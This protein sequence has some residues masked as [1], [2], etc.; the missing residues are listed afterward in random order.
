MGSQADFPKPETAQEPIAIVGMACRFPG[1]ATS[2]SKLWD[3][4]AAGQDGWSPIPKSRFDAE[5]LYHADKERLGRSH[6]TGGYF[7]KEDVALFDAPF[8]NFPAELAKVSRRKWEEGNTRYSK[9]HLT[10]FPRRWTPRYVC[11]SRSSTK[12]PRMVCHRPPP[13]LSSTNPRIA[14]RE[15]ICTAGVPLERLAGSDTSVFAGCFGK[16]YYD[17]LTRDLELLP[18]NFFVGTSITMISNRISHFYDLKGASVTLDTA[19]SSGLVALHQAC[20][21]LRSGESSMAIVGAANAMLSPDLFVA[22]STLGVVGKD[23]KCYAWDPR[24]EGYGRG[25]GVAAL[26][27][28]PLAAALADGDHVHSVIRD[29]GLN[30]DG[31]TPTITSPSLDAQVDLIRACYRRAGLDMSETGYVE[32]HMTGTE[33]GDATEAEALGRTFGRS[34]AADDGPVVVGSVKTNIGHTEAVSGLAAVIKATLGLRHRM[35]AP[36]LNFETTSPKIDAAGWHLTVPT[37]PQPWPRDKPLRVSINNFGYGGTNAHVILEGASSHVPTKP[38]RNGLHPSAANGTGHA[39]SVPKVYVVTAKD[40][41]ALEKASGELAAHLRR[42]G[43]QGHDRP[44]EGDLAYTLAQRRSRFP[45]VSAVRAS[46]LDDLVDGLEDPSR[47][48]PRGKAPGKVPRV[49]FVFNGQGAQWYRMGR[50][51]IAAYPVF[52]TAIRKADEAFRQLGAEWSLF[53]ELMRDEESTRVSRIDLTQPITVALQICLVD[54]LES[55]GIVPEAVC[56]HSSG[57]IAAAYAAGALT[58]VEA[59]GVVYFRGKLALEHLDA[60]SPASSG[61]IAAGIGPDQAR[62]YIGDAGVT[63]AGRVV[64]ACVNSPESVTLS[65]DM[66]AID[67]VLE[68]LNGDGHFARKLKVPVAYHSHHMLPMAKDYSDCLHRI[69]AP[70][71][72]S[73]GKGRRK[74]PEFAS[75]VTGGLVRAR[76]LSPEHWVRNLTNPVLFSQAFESMCSG[77]GGLDEPRADSANAANSSRIDY[78]VEIGPHSTLFGPIRQ[79]LNGRSLGYASCL[80]RGVDAVETMQDMVCNLLV[81]GYPVDLTAVNSPTGQTHTLV[82]GLPTYPWNHSNRYWLESRL[83]RELRHKKFPP[84]ELLGLPLSGSISG[85]KHTWRNFLRVADIP[86]LADHRVDSA[87]VLPAAA[88]I[89]MAIE[90]LRLVAAPSEKTLRGYALRDVDIRNALSIPESSVGVEVQTCLSPCDE[91]E[92][93]HRGWYEFE[94]F[95]LHAGGTWIE[96][97]KGFVSLSTMGST[98]TGTFAA[99]SPET[100]DEASFFGDGADVRGFEGASMYELM[101]SMNFQHG[102]AF[103]N[104][105]SGRKTKTK[106][107]VDLTVSDAGSASEVVHPTTLDSVIVTACGSDSEREAGTSMML[108]RSIGRMFVGS[109]IPRGAGDRLR[110][111]GVVTK[112]DRRGSWIGADVSH[113]DGR[114]APRSVLEIRDFFFQAVPLARPEGGEAA[115]KAPVCYKARWELDVLHDMPGRLLDAWRISL[116][117]K[118]AAFERKLLQASYHLIHDSVAELEREEDG[119]SWAWHHR[120]FYRWMRA[121][122][123]LGKSGAIH[124]RS[125]SWSRTGRGLKQLL[126]DEL[127]DADACGRLLVRVGRQLTDIVRGSV[128]PLELMMEDNLLNQYY[129]DLPR[130]K[131]RTYKHLRE[132]V[133]LFAVKNPGAKVLEIGG[134]TGGA[135][136]IVLQSFGGGGRGAARGDGSSGSLLDHYTFTDISSGFFEAAKKKLAPWTPDMTFQ[137]LD[138]ERDPAQQG[139]A[140]GAYDLVVAFMVL[141]AT[142]NLRNTMANVRKLLRPGGTL[143]MIETTQDRLDIQLIFGTVPGWWLSE[144]PER[145]MSPNVSLQAWDR[146]L[147]ETGFS[148]VD[149]H[150]EDCEQA[151]FQCSSVIL[152]TAEPPER[153]S[154]PPPFVSIVYAEA[155]PQAWLAELAD[156]I[157]GV[158]GAAPTVQALGEFDPHPDTTCVF[159]AE[160]EAPLLDGMDGVTFERVRRLLV[161]SRGVLWLS[162]GG[163][164][165]AGRPAFGQTQGLLRTLRQEDTSKTVVHVDLEAAA[166]D[167]DAS[168]SWDARDMGHVGHVFRQAFGYDRDAAAAELDTEYAVRDS[169]LH[170]V[171]VYGDADGDGPREEDAPRTRRFAQPGRVLRWKPS[172][173]GLLSEMRFEE[174]D[175]TGDDALPSGMVEIAPK[176]FAL[177]FRDVMV[178][179]G[180]LDDTL[181]SHDTAGVVTRLGPGT[182]GSGLAVGDRVCG[183]A[184]GRFAGTDR[185]HAHAVAR[186]PDGMP[187]EHAAALPVVYVTAWHSLVRVAGLARGESV[188]IHAAAG[189]VGQAAIVVAQSVGAEVYATC[190]TEAKRDLLVR[191]YA[192]PP[193]RVLGS[194]DDSFAAAVMGQTGG[195]GVDVV[196]NSL[197]GPLLKASW[198]C[199]AR[200]GRFVEIGKTDIEASR[201]LDMAAFGRCATYAGVDV[202]QLNVYD[203]ARVREALRESLRILSDR[204]G[205]APVHPIETYSIS[206]ME[207]AMRKMQSGSHL[208]KLVLIPAEDAC[209]KVEPRKHS[210]SLDNPDATY[211]IIGGLGGVARAIACWMM[212]KGARNLLLISRN[213]ESHPEAQKLAGEAGSRGCNLQVRNCDAS[214]EES[215]LELLRAVTGDSPASMPPIRGVINGAMVLDDTVLERMTY[216]QWQR[217][218]RPK[219]ASSVNVHKHLPDLSFFVMLSSLTGV[220][221]NVSQANYAAGNTFQDALAR[222]RAARGQ[223]AVSIDLSAVNSVGFVAAAAAA[224]ARTDGSGA[225]DER[226]RARVEGLGTVSLD[227]DVILGV[228]ERAVV[229]SPRRAR[230]DDAQVVVGL[231]PWDRLPPRSAVRRDRRFG[232]LR[233]GIPRGA[234]AGES[235]DAGA[236]AGADPTAA[237]GRALQGAAGTEEEEAARGVAAAIAARLAAIFSVAVDEIDLGASLSS[238]GVDS[239]VAVELRNW[240]G[241]AARAKVTVFEITQAASLMEFAKLVRERS[242]VGA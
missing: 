212:E 146:V 100:P 188:L 190:S 104:L 143:I 12:Q 125:P 205:L 137:A 46:S 44:S 177:N 173:S 108:P 99:A 199:V 77:G 69:L 1:D 207:Q 52:G 163:I 31:K 240:L 7:L 150:I 75:P 222:H 95:S 76:D 59:L 30:Q 227:M 38:V 187:W 218:V 226:V 182:E 241:S 194:R 93:D 184:S 41:T 9:L 113:E 213:A 67:A 51:L 66:P 20:Q 117:D 60:P 3:M 197:S 237:L 81:S 118:E 230:P 107:M 135:T 141:H 147:R 64:V 203:G 202:N 61:M 232:T 129:M 18:A 13:A 161:G 167:G 186:I 223:A 169:M 181:V 196:L 179:L 37:Q 49:G 57:E 109:D 42:G 236:A 119:N 235:G 43:Q 239:L 5:S 97:C 116:S 149:G 138:I 157:G 132:V 214:D 170:V 145:N 106:V 96:N 39:E 154:S 189:G 33:V 102:P 159:V 242:A 198:D 134:G 178:A 156:T 191:R 168:A 73:G 48:N 28:K 55:W 54:L 220:A 200:F 10:A 14:N 82:P 110:Y 211:L 79:I 165:D 124:P 131:D 22:M 210:V 228:V 158:T 164:V 94:V 115:G 27:L 24:A 88:Y 112:S 121:V 45:W 80:K 103:R 68:R 29:V 229:R 50:E 180:Q 78:V 40:E 144:E 217:A 8:F 128:T 72:D 47:K 127:S 120:I 152:S 70:S 26:M 35:I 155:P 206:D 4:C 32:A 195:R 58:F 101:R 111:F 142:K 86:W 175:D 36:N 174:S 139:L 238:R 151:E 85:A 6:V 98:K 192:I 90:A 92:L 105:G 172:D 74:T 62:A 63:A 2:P 231:A 53:D 21:T 122:V 25:E 215:F 234:G 114:G 71:R 133:E 11:C 209:V 17:I 34:R 204:Q 153:P 221:G 123:D 136:E 160:F 16:D 185:A 216:D 15:I 201:R 87:V 233:L 148:G 162:R 65:G 89:T 166:G 183:I 171:R 130:L 208:G 19:C 224:A 193:G 219:V 83:D 176:A 23:G 56:S 126:Y 91:R 225:A 140:A 84:N